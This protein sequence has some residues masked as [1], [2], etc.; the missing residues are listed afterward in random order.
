MVM[1]TDI[2]N[3]YLMAKLNDEQREKPIFSKR[4]RNLW[5]DCILL[6][7]SKTRTTIL[8]DSGYYEIC[9][10]ESSDCFNSARHLWL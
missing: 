9:H 8:Q 7:Y 5:E 10:Q 3:E 6:V 2:D 1:E 4:A